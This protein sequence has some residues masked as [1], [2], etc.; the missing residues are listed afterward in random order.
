MANI[1]PAGALPYQDCTKAAE[2][3]TRWLVQDRNDTK[4]QREILE[5]NVE[6][7]A[8]WPEDS[9]TEFLQDE[10]LDSTHPLDKEEH[11]DDS[12]DKMD[13]HLEPRCR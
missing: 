4:G 6:L 8:Y 5:V 10:R 7:I 3:S 9:K 1:L 13:K 2:E 11:S 12:D